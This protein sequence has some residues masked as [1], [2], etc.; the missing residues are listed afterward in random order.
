MGKVHGQIQS[1]LSLARPRTVVKT[2]LA[3]QAPAHKTR[4]IGPLTFVQNCLA[5]RQKQKQS[6]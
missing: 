4:V 2:Q 5:P 6:M 1:H 3:G